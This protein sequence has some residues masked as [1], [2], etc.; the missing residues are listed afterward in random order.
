MTTNPTELSGWVIFD[1]PYEMSSAK[2]VSIVRRC[3]KTKKAGHA[4]TLDPLATGILPIALG[5]AT[6]T[7]PYAMDTDKTYRFSVAWGEE[8]ETDDREGAVLAQSSKRPSQAEIQ[9]FLPSFI[10]KI[11]Q[12]PPLYSAL[13]IQGKR[14]CDRAREGEDFVL[15]PRPVT[16]YELTIL[17]HTSEATEFELHCGKGTYVRSIARDLGRLLGT[18]GYVSSLRRIAVGPFLEKDSVSIDKLLELG[19]H[20]ELRLFVKPLDMV[21]D[22]IPAISLSDSAARMLR[23]GRSLPG[24]AFIEKDQEVAEDSLV[25]CKSLDGMPL[26]IAQWQDK[27]VK[28]LRVFNL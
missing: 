5:E 25:V 18:Y 9:N 13:K 26:A 6:K 8:R 2:A 20:S 3:F 11:D 19:P 24:M 28:P 10:G 17:H 21:L 12:V 15:K 23:Q 14:A 7:I 4:G 27:Q 22:D 1:K 16:V